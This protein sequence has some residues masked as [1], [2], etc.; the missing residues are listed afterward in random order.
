VNLSHNQISQIHKKTFPYSKWVPYRLEE[1]DLSSNRLAVI[2]RD[3]TT[4]LKDLKKL[5]LA[6]NS[7]IET[8]QYVIG[9]LTK[10]QELDLS[11][12]QMTHFRDHTIGPNPSMRVLKLQNNFLLVLP[13]EML[14]PMRNLTLLDVSGNRIRRFYD[15]LMPWIENGTQVL[16]HDN[17]MR[18]DCSLRQLRYWMDDRIFD[19]SSPWPRVTCA[20]PEAMRGQS[21][22]ALD[23]KALDCV[24]PE[25][26]GKR[27]QQ[28]PDIV[29]RSVDSRA[30]GLHL[31]WYVNTREDVGDFLVFARAL[32]ET[33]PSHTDAV[34][35]WRRR[36]RVPVSPGQKYVVCVRALTSDGSLRPYV[37][38]QC[39]TVSAAPAPPA[40]TLAILAAALGVLKILVW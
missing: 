31:S 28:K 33:R 37:D 17:Q 19:L 30:G 10:L 4:G 12:N 35:Y 9:N 8:R 24:G 6:N 29:F 7:L 20:S 32:N 21:V 23:V 14:Q 25:Q 18:C 34:A 13:M 39:R 11:N 3:F 22:T 26:D 27:Y 40:A 38:G 36:A 5:S 16:Y 2:G 1:L 15:Q